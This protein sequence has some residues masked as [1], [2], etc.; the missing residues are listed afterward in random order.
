MKLI[1]SMMLDNKQGVLDRIAG[2]V[3]RFGWN[4]MSVIASDTNEE[5]EKHLTLIL[6]SKG[7]VESPEEKIKAQDFIR[8]M[9]L[10]DEEHFT[11]HELLIARGA[12]EKLEPFLAESATYSEAE[13]VVTAFYVGDPSKISGIQNRLN[14]VDGIKISR[15]GTVV[16]PV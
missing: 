1:Y 11:F 5:D 4:I 3:R 8:S 7:F 9:T 13:N 12:K 6:E 2:I 10:C 15:S 14:D 16:L